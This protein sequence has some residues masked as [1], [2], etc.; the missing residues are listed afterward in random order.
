MRRATLACMLLACRSFKP[1]PVGDATPPRVAP[2]A[3]ASHATVLAA[4]NAREVVTKWN[5]AH[6]EHDSRA[7]QDLYGPV[8]SFYGQ[9]LTNREC[10]SMKKAAFD[11][12]PDYAQS[13]KDISAQ[14]EHPG[15]TV[16]RFTKT[17]AAGGKSTDY[18]AVLF[19]DAASLITYESDEV[20]NANIEKAKAATST[21]C[22]DDP[23]GSFDF[24]H[25]HQGHRALQD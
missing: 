7:L 21:W 1:A 10:V 11:R 17:S 23:E 14:T 12:S 13:V 8:V 9:S 4:P 6:N 2:V 24:H 5:Q 15:L 20:T 19:L 16:V 25:Q 3:D 18:K 22:L